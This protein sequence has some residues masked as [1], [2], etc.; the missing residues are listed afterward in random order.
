[1]MPMANLQVDMTLFWMVGKAGRE[2]VVAS[3]LRIVGA[4][5]ANS[6]SIV[7]M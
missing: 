4:D 1:M 6:E 7:K 5:L 2:A 3:G